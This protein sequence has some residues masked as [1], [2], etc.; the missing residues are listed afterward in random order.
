MHISGETIIALII[1]GIFI[2]VV[3]IVIFALF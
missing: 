2:G 3:S 1:T